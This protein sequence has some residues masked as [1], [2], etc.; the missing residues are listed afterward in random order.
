MEYRT[1]I[2]DPKT[3]ARWI[4]SFTHELGRLEQVV[5]SNIKGTDTI[6]FVP[7][8]QIPVDR[9][10]Q[11]TY[12]KIVVDYKPNISEMYRTRITVG[13]DRIEYP[14]EVITPTA[15][16]VTTKL[17]INSVISTPGARFMTAYIGNFYLGTPME[18]YEY[19]VI[20]MSIIPQ[21]IITQYKLNDLQRQGKVY[22]EIRRGVYG[23]PHAGLLAQQQ[24]TQH[25]EPSGYVPCRHTHGLWRHR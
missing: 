10:K 4:R 23:L 22:I 16:I 7:Y 8:R 11:I 9:R 13:G 24:L 12:G 15:D 21:E 5:G 14:G 3:R 17:L 20:P 1:L 19:M 2:K 6:F 25:L 18:R